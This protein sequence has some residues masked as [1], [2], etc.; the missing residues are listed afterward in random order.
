MPSGGFLPKVSTTPSFLGTYTNNFPNPIQKLSIPN[1]VFNSY[2]FAN[3]D[4][5]L[6]RMPGDIGDIGTYQV[7][8]GPF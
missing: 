6:A 7:E 4:D 8:E 5:P 1:I 2:S 3:Y